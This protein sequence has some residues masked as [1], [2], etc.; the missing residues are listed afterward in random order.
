MAVASDFKN[1]DLPRRKEELPEMTVKLFLS[2]K[3][4][5][6]DFTRDIDAGERVKIIMHGSAGARVTHSGVNNRG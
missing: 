3:K 5:A 6:P 2:L 4:E 1:V